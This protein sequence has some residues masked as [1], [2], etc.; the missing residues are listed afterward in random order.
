MKAVVRGKHIAWRTLN[1]RRE[2]QKINDLILYVKFFKNKNRSTWKVVEDG[3][4]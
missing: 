1:K 4:R 2:I 3:K